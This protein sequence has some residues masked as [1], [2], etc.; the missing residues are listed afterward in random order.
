MRGSWLICILLFGA[1]SVK[2]QTGIN[3]AFNSEGKVILLPKKQNYVLEFTPADYSR[4]TLKPV[5]TITLE[6][7]LREFVFDI[8][9]VAFDDDRPMNR[10]I[11]SGAY[12]PFYHAYTP[13]LRRVSPMALDFNE[14]YFTPMSENWAFVVNGRQY[15]WP[16]LGGQTTVE[17][18]LVWASGPVSVVG[19]GFAGR[20][21]TP[22]N[23]SPGYMAGGRLQLS[24]DVHER[25]T[26]RSWGQ[27]AY[28]RET[29]FMA[30]GRKG[31]D[32]PHMLMN[33][34]YNHTS[35]G[36]AMEFKISEDFGVGL[37]VNYEYNPWN[38]R[39]DRQ[40]LLYPVM[41]SKKIQIRVQ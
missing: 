12:L 11:Q 19:S 5:T 9:Q 27:Y 2:A 15:T 1:L 22:F 14:T 10:I 41:N 24:V 40:F 20:H 13:M 25:V 31:G 36:G 32:N 7:R 38:R 29:N 23:P 35:V 37:G 33:P 17:S 30:P 39:M 4:Y 16:G 18:G 3:R 28:Y 26:L 6:S 21:Y 8:P 34:F